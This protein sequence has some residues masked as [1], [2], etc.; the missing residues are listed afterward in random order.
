MTRQKI[1]TKKWIIAGI[2]AIAFGCLFSS[3][4]MKTAESSATKTTGDSSSQV[5][6]RDSIVSFE[7]LFAPGQYD[8]FLGKYWSEGCNNYLYP[9]EKA[10]SRSLTCPCTGILPT[11]AN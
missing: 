4:N 2:A 6:L 10:L 8:L 9:I 3:C 5:V 7:A 11:I 1:E